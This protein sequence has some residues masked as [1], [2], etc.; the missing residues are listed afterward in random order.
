MISFLFFFSCSPVVKKEKPEYKGNKK[1]IVKKKN[2][3]LTETKNSWAYDDNSVDE[4]SSYSNDLKYVDEIVGKPDIGT[5]SNR[6]FDKY[7]NKYWGIPYRLGGE[8]PKKNLDC[9]AYV[10]LM[11]NEAA[12]VKLPRSSKDQFKKGKYIKEMN[13]LQYGDLV[14]FKMNF[15][16]ISHVGI[17]IGDNKFTHASTSQGVTISD[18]NNKY[19]KARF[20]G[21]RRI[22]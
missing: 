10:R 13:E 2:R 15:K 17:Y 16:A 1:V 21:G 9:S 8:N 7:I 18:L 12:G 6:I 3:N 14:F 4:S 22:W 19:Y 5:D 11:F 20:A